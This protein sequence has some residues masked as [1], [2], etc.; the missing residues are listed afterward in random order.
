[1][2]QTHLPSQLAKLA[3][4]ATTYLLR[5]NKHTPA[6]LHITVY[7]LANK[8]AP[9]FKFSTVGFFFNSAPNGSSC[10]VHNKK[11][12]AW[13]LWKVAL[14][15]VI[16]NTHGKTFFAFTTDDKRFKE[17]T[18]NLSLCLDNFTFSQANTAHKSQ[19]KTKSRQLQ[20]QATLDHTKEIKL[21]SNAHLL[22]IKN[23]VH[24]KRYLHGQ[25]INNK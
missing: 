20:K 18:N 16:A 11:A 14:G 3:R 7:G 12:R 4:F 21:G 22:H 9:W 10:N 15:I 5:Y 8:N 19:E 23:Q 17:K 2:Q 24:R 13:N 25:E 6:M 1:M